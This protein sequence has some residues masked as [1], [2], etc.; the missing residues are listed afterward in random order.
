MVVEAEQ[1]AAGQVVIS[2]LFDKTEDNTPETSETEE[3]T[4][5]TET[6]ETEETSETETK[7]QETSSHSPETESE[8]TENGGSDGPKTGDSVPVTALIIL[9]LISASGICVILSRRGKE[10]R[11]DI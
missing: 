7:Q 2:Y 6:D 4:E 3:T 8:K 5:T 1:D 11:R 9:L 10:K